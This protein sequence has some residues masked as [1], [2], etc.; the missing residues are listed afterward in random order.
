MKRFSLCMIIMICMICLMLAACGR[1]ADTEESGISDDDKYIV[2]GLS[3][4]GAES[5]WRV[6]DS[7]SMKQT[8][9]E[10]KGY[11]LLF[12]DA[13]QKQENQI[14]A[15][16]KYIQQRVD[17]IVLMPVGE[18]GWDSVLQEAKHAGI[19]VIVVDRMV[20]VKDSSL[21]TAHVGADFYSEGKKAVEWIEGRYPSGRNLHIVHIQGTL[22]STAQIGRTAALDD[23]LSK[24]PE[25]QLLARMDGDFTQAKTYEAM[26]DYLENAPVRPIIDVVYCENDNEAF[27]A[28]EALEAQGYLCGQ[29]GVSVISF[30]ATHDALVAVKNGK[31]SLCVE[32]NPMLGP[33]VENVI[34]EIEAG[35]VPE[36]NHYVEEA[37]FTQ[38]DVTDELLE[39]REY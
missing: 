31:L 23:A 8:F 27:G 12:D 20:N 30:D 17:Y 32:C 35:K 6:A 2:I 33:L 28:V 10:E 22:G 15:V 4:V 13:R 7:E 18:D 26:S 1:V 5:D 29:G 38:H 3:Q 25:W 24:H 14:G 34:Q 39:S 16:R 9:T 11:R 19:P 37:V 21:V 36:K